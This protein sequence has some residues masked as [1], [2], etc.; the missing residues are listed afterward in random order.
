MTREQIPGIGLLAGV[1]FLSE[2]VLLAALAFIGAAMFDSL[3]LSIVA[4]IA[5]PLAAAVIWG[6]FIAP[7]APRHLG[8]PARTIVEV[9]IFGVTV[10]GLLVYGYLVF[11]I[12]LAVLFAGG[13]VYDRRV[14]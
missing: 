10:V 2:L 6:T 5:L 12:V 9:L 14:S 1:R 13:K 7:R 4:G 3:V 8:Q 11:G